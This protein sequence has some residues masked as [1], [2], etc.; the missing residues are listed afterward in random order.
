VLDLDDSL[1]Q[2]LPPFPNIDSTI[3]IR[4]LLNHTCG[5]FNLTEN[6]ATWDSVFADPFRMVSMEA[7]ITNCTLEPYF[8]P[9]S[10]WHYCNTGY[11]LLRLLIPEATNSDI[12]QEYR[13]RFFTPLGMT[14]A[15]VAPYETAP[16]TIAQGWFDC[17][18]NG[19][20]DELPYMTSFYSMAGGGVFC[21]A[22]ELAGWSYALL[23]EKTVLSQPSLDEM[24]TFHSPC[25]GEEMAG[26]YGLGVV[27]FEASLF[28]GLNLYGH[29]GNAL[30][31]AAGCFYL[32]DYGVSLAVMD[33]TEHGEC[34][35]VITDLLDVLTT[36]LE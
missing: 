9:G 15:F 20:Y 31:Y 27:Q 21:T 10:D 11:L 32:P 5:I 35:W 28:N 14:T 2:W 7:I 30:G 34:M 17:D 29:G 8:E 26:G 19:T 1:S 36:H 33:N 24:L 13:D 3:T 4:Q 25:P 16:A 23:H 12:H 18:G 6:T 22:R